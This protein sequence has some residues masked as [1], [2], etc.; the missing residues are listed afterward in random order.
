MGRKNIYVDVDG[1]L[2][3]KDVRNSVDVVGPNP[4]VVAK[5]KA[6]AAE[7]HRIIVWS[8]RGQGYAEKAAKKF[9]I[10]AVACLG[11]PHMII[12]DKP[13]RMKNR[14]K[15]RTMDVKDFMADEDQE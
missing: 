5:V 4:E 13:H 11:K 12:D 7:G 6:L 9:G 2:T 3:K 15:R 10:P 14:W 1:T 8:T